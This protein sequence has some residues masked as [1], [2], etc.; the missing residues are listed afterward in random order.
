M[1]YLQ[2]HK[3]LNLQGSVSISG[4]KN[5]ALPI[6]AATLL[7]SNEVKISNLPDVADVKTLAKL[8]EHLGVNIMW[9]NSNTLTCHAEPFMIL[10]AKCV[11]L[12]LC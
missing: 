10:C 11:P 5:S 1:D 9:E 4:A 7:S 8:L 3:S 6:L 12:S 2:I